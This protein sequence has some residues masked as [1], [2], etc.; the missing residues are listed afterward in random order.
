[1]AIFANFWGKLCMWCI[2]FFIDFLCLIMKKLL[3]R[4][5]EQGFVLP[6][7]VVL[8]VL[9]ERGLAPNWRAMLAFDCS[10]WAS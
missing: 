6:F 10:E 7:R 9:V 3:A 1:M 4:G 2:K 5:Q 8:V